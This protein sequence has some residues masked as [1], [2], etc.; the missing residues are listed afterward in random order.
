[1]AT[2]KP[3]QHIERVFSLAQQP[4]GEQPNADDRE[5]GPEKARFWLLAVVDRLG[6]LIIDRL[7]IK[8]DRLIIIIAAVAAPTRAA[9]HWVLCRSCRDLGSTNSG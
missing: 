7:P 1:V 5:E 9:A 2:E 8:T 6:L 3:S 4:T